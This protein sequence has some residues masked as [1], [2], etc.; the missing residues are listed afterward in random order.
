M[1]ARASSVLPQA[2]PITNI[3]TAGSDLADPTPAMGSV[4]ITAAAAASDAVPTLSEWMLMALA[5]AMTAL[6]M[7]KLRK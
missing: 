5:G 1:A 2:G 6:A 4:T 7:L 3:S